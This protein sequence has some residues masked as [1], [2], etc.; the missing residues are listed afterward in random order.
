MPRGP[1]ETFNFSEADCGPDFVEGQKN[2]GVVTVELE[3]VLCVPVVGRMRGVMDGRGNK[4][5]L[6][7]SRSMFDNPTM[8]DGWSWK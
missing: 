2:S 7:I 8:A 1:C 6:E 5:S 3:G 4:S